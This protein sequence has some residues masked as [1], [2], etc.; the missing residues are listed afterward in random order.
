M[1]QMNQSLQEW[2]FLL[3]LSILAKTRLKHHW[4]LL[5]SVYILI[6]NVYLNW[7]FLFFLTPWISRFHDP[8]CHS[9]TLLQCMTDFNSA[10]AGRFHLYISVILELDFPCSPA[11]L[12]PRI[13]HNPSFPSP[14]FLI[15][16]PH[17][18]SN[19]PTLLPTSPDS[20][21]EKWRDQLFLVYNLLRTIFLSK[22]GAG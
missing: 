5:L 7:F 17:P 15:F 6:S 19:L 1:G 11:L 13:A 22:R 3:G 14:T 21:T 12:P 2:I 16:P 4:C 9:A 18:P 10:L 20:H 8:F